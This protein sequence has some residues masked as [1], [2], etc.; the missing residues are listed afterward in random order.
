MTSWLIAG[1]VQVYFKKTRYINLD[2]TWS[3]WILDAPPPAPTS[4]MLINPCI[5]AS[6]P[7]SKQKWCDPTVEIGERVADMIARMSVSEKI[8]ALRDASAPIPSLGLPYYDWWNEAT[9]GTDAIFRNSR[10]LQESDVFGGT[11]LSGNAVYVQNYADK[12]NFCDVIHQRPR[13]RK[14]TQCLFGC[15]WAVVDSTR[16]TRTAAPTRSA[17]ALLCAKRHKQGSHVRTSLSRRRLIPCAG[18]ASGAL[19]YVKEDL[20]QPV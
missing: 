11:V 20:A 9:H 17:S 14:Q 16:R 6:Y 1:I 2:G 8:G 4:P 18:N 5:N 7:Q 12:R 10:T 15:S 3:S 13:R 19:A